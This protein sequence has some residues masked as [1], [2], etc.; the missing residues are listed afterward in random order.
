MLLLLL[1]L[2]LSAQ[3]NIAHYASQVYL[4]RRASTGQS[5]GRGVASSAPPVSINLVPLGQHAHDIVKRIV[6]NGSAG[7]VLDKAPAAAGAGA[8]AAETPKAAGQLAP[9]QK[10]IK[11]DASLDHPVRLGAPPR[12][13]RG[14]ITNTSA[15]AGPRPTNFRVVIGTVHPASVA[16]AAPDA[17]TLAT[18]DSA[19]KVEAAAQRRAGSW[20]ASF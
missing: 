17:D 18:A 10:D 2:L 8:A 5:G 16:H 20:A 7:W 12:T 15:P 13:V 4:R 11:L 6:A 19:R 14:N 3:I 9:G 1:L